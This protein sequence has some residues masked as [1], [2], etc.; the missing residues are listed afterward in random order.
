VRAVAPPFPGAFSDLAGERLIIAAA[1]LWTAPLPAA[2]ATDLSPG[3][4]VADNRVFALCGDGRA[5]L[6]KTL[7]RERD[8]AHLDAA[9]LLPLLS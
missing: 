2:L 9:D 5:L 8:G 4:R 6:V 7:V 3:L 1:R